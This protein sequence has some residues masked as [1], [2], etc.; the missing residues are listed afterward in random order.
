MV[1]STDTEPLSLVPLVGE[2]MYAAWITMLKTLV[3]KDRARRLKSVVAAM[4]QFAYLRIDQA[5]NH[6]AGLLLKR[7]HDWMGDGDPLDFLFPIAEKLCRDAGFSSVR[8]QNTGQAGGLIY[9]AIREFVIWPN[10]PW[11]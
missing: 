11:E 10:R 9:D 1:E 4:L 8:A 3:P 5:P 7:A 2:D 6:E